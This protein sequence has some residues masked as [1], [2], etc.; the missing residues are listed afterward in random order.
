MRLNEAI[1]QKESGRIQGEKAIGNKSKIALSGKIQDAII[2]YYSLEFIMTKYN[3][4][5]Q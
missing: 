1:W 5:L 4:S 3:E 2:N